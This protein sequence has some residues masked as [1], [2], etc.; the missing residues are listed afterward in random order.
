MDKQIIE[1][2]IADIWEDSP[3]I[4]VFI[5]HRDMIKAAAH[6]LAESLKP[7]G[8]SCF[9]AHDSIEASSQ[10][11][12]EIMRAM[13]SMEVFLAMV[14]AN[15]HDSSFTNQEVGYA[16]A[17]QN[18]V[19]IVPI[20]LEEVALEGFLQDI[21]GIKGA[22]WID[23]GV[24]NKLVRTIEKNV[25]KNRVSSALVKA[26]VDSPSFPETMKRYERLRRVATELSPS[27]EELLIQGFSRNDQLHNCGAIVAGWGDQ[28]SIDAFLKNVTGKSFKVQRRKLK[29]LD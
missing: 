21:Q 8:M 5:S 9:V 19:C 18:D 20:L 29:V 1:A 16:L 13:N 15:F 17:R 6:K 7:F 24:L 25:P 12:N 28:P 23:E 11:V 3:A 10:W 26:L 4:R 27:D 22:P 2:D 14:S